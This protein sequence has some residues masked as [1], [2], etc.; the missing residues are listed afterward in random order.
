M[1][2]Q[3]CIWDPAMCM[4]LSGR[5]TGNLLQNLCHELVLEYLGCHS[6]PATA[7]AAVGQGVIA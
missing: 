1:P 4:D 7:Q 3:V 5:Y 6:K 2:F